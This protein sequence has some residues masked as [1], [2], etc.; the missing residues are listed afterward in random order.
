MKIDKKKILLFVS[1]ILIGLA[2]TMQLKTVKKTVGN[3]LNVK[4]VQELAQRVKSLEEERDGLLQKLDNAEDKLR[5]YEKPGSSNNEVAKKLYE[6]TEKYKMIA[7]YTDLKGKGIILTIDEPK[8]ADGEVS[9]GIQND[10]DLILSA[11]SVLNSAG[12]EAI[13]INEVRYTSFTEIVS[14]GK[15]IEVGGVSTSAPIVIKAIGDAGTMQS[16]IE[17]KGG[18]KDE[19]QNYNYQVVLTVR[20]DIVIPRYKKSID[21]LYA[22]PVYEVQEWCIRLNA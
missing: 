19:L 4:R 15:H 13:S 2:I 21:F 18:I 3:P 16:A 20:D 7:G 11:I 1:C 8:L 17:F 22:K 14:A 10:I 12:A 5:E 9:F 6:E